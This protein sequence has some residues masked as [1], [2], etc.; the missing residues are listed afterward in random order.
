MKIIVGGIIEKDNKI[1]MVKEAKKKCYG[2]WNVPAGHLENGETIFEGAIREIFEE[3]GCKVRLKNVL[4][5]MSKDI[6]DTTLIIITFTTELLEENI[7]FNK[8]GILDVKWISKKEL[9]N[10]TDKELRDEKRIKRT[11]KMLEEN[12]VYPLNSIKILEYIN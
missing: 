9:I 10:M 7:S 6:E 4:P 2:K 1:L 11:L 8:E 3:T 5:I 12:K